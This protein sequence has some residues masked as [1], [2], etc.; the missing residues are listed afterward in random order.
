MTQIDEL[1]KLFENFTTLFEQ[2]TQLQQDKISAVRADDIGALDHCMQ[3]EQA[4]ILKLR[5]FQRQKD[6]LHKALGLTNVS[7]HDILNHLP[8]ARTQLEPI[9]NRMDTAYKIYQSAAAASRS[10][11]EGGLHEI[12]QQLT[13]FTPPTQKA[14][15]PAP[16]TG[17]H[18]TDIKA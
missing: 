6:T 7:F 12:E 4:M 8:N 17:G 10:A 13:Q 16:R 2:L 14:S 5:G 3:Q 18:F 11:L 1:S 9:I 15:A